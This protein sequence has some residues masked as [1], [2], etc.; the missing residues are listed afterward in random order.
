MP[1]SSNKSCFFQSLMTVC[2]KLCFPM[3]NHHTY[4]NNCPP[5][6]HPV[7]TSLNLSAPFMEI[8][9]TLTRDTGRQSRVRLSSTSLLQSLQPWQHVNNRGKTSMAMATCQWPWQHVNDHGITSIT[10]ATHQW[11]WSHVNKVLIYLVCCRIWSKC[12]L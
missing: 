8:L 4:T 3:C 2:K 10:L 11:R 9:M 5:P 1:I 12:Q 6:L 7:D